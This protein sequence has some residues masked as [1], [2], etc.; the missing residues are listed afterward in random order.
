MGI[1]VSFLRSS[2]RVRKERIDKLL[3]SRGLCESRERAQ[4]ALMAG[5]VF[6]EGRRVE[7]PGERVPE[8]AEIELRGETCPYV[9]RG[10]L[11]L[12]KALDEFGI[13]L[14][15]KVCLD[16][17]AST[18]GF[19]DCMLKEG[20]SKVYAVDVGY[21]Q[22]HWSLRNDPRVISIERFNARYL[23]REIIPEPIDFFGM[24]LSFIS[25]RKVLRAVEGLLK[26]DGEGVILVKPQF[27]AG[28]EYVKGG[29]VRD[30]EIHIRVIEDVVSFLY[31]DLR[32][33]P[34]GLTFSPIKGPEGNIEFLLHVGFREIGLGKERIASVVDLAHLELGE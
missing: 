25:V 28:R 10:G 11:K 32:L 15:G 26:F 4:R 9:S 17:G 33:R 23:S 6:V 29:V 16:V 8:D 1:G 34:L 18:G 12:K 7:K 21:G 24:D 27:E 31:S 19:T 13:S 22:L 3:V 5:M 30:R 14:K 2:S 20:A